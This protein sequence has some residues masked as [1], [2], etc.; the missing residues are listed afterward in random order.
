MT[1][2]FRIYYAVSVFNG[3]GRDWLEAPHGIQVV[4]V[5]VPPPAPGE[6]LPDRFLTGYV[7]CGLSD[8]MLY[9]GID[10]YDTLGF[11]VVK[12]GSLLSDAA[13]LAVWEWACGDR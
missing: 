8:R 11:G 3:A 9:T 13:Y 1:H 6:P 7:H 2:A 4:A 12:Y 10:E 5:F